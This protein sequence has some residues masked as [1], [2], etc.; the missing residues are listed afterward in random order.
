MQKLR[1]KLRVVL[2]LRG[3]VEHI[4]R[5]DGLPPAGIA[6]LQHRRVGIVD[7]AVVHA[8]RAG[9][10]NKQAIGCVAG[11]RALEDLPAVLHAPGKEAVRQLAAGGD[12]DDELVRVGLRRVLE[13]LILAR[14]LVGVLLV[15]NDDVAVEGIL[16]VRAGGQCV[17]ADEAR[18]ADVA[19]DGVLDVVVDDPQAVLRIVRDRQA[20]PPDVVG[21]KIEALQRLLECA[22]DLVDL[23]PAGRVVERQ[24]PRQSRGK[25]RFD[26]LAR[27]EILRLGE[28][29]ELRAGDVKAHDVKH[30][31]QV[32][33]QQLERGPAQRCAVQKFALLM[34]HHRFDDG[35]DLAGWLAAELPFRIFKVAHVPLTGKH[36]LLTG[37]DL[38]GEHAGDI[39]VHGC[40]ILR[41]VLDRELAG[42]LQQF[43][44]ARPLRCAD[45]GK[46]RLHGL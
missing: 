4:L 33:R 11:D 46:L 36:D 20:K 18:V 30:N 7:V 8:R 42:L 19:G 41:R 14:V 3:V 23:G 1:A 32:I 39:A 9:E 24:G 35:H 2:C 34:A 27:D 26:V 29:P 13:H 22:A 12:A 25:G 43:I 38:A 6:A 45:V 5:A 10:E 31:E 44:Q 16:L 15:G 40:L 37:D 21:D 28:A 17:D